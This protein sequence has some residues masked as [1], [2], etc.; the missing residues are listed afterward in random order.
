[1]SDELNKEIVRRY[2]M[3]YV[4][5]GDLTV[6]DNVLKSEFLWN[7][8]LASIETH[9]HNVSQWHNGFPDIQFTVEDLI[10]DGDRV[11]ERCMATGT[12][13]G[14]CFGIAPTG[15]KI[16]ALGILIHHIQGG[17]IAEIWEVIDLYTVFGQLG[18]FPPIS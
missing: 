6:A 13:T 2:R 4:A 7:G 17:Q 5:A 8:E 11:V 10:V 18:V 16:N 1:M 12:H 9:K 14:E 3:E 15:K